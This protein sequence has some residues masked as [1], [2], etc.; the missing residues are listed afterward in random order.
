MYSIKREQN[1]KKGKTMKAKALEAIREFYG[2]EDLYEILEND[3]EDLHDS[4]VSA[5]CVECGFFEGEFEPD[6]RGI[7]CSQCG[8][9]KV[10]SIVEI[11]LF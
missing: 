2:I 9:Y 7:K 11:L 1:S 5:F 4:I 6:A 8:E 10:K 3:S